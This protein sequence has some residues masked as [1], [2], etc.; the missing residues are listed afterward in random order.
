MITREELKSLKDAWY[1][2]EEI[3]SIKLWLKNIDEWKT[4]SE[5]KF[6]WNIYKKINSKM[7]KHA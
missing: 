3:E 1:T 7:K 2:F 4:I 6:W 5:D